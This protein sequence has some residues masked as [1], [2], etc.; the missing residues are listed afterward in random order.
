M[1]PSLKGSTAP[2]RRR[3]RWHRQLRARVDAAGMVSA[4]TLNASAMQPGAK[5]IAP[6]KYAPIIATTTALARMVHAYATSYTTEVN[7]NLRFAQENAIRTGNAT[8]SSGGATANRALAA[9][10]A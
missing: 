7:A 4:S 3:T 8:S 5:M 9:L 1:A 6:C 10:A 2:R